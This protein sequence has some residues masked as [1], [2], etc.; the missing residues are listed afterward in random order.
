MKKKGKS[1]SKI[2][3]FITFNCYISWVMRINRTGK[4]IKGFYVLGHASVPVYLLD[5]PFPALFDA[6]FTGLARVYEKGILEVL[7][8]CPPS[9][10][11]LT[12]AHWDHIGSAAYFKAVWPQ[13]QIAGSKKA[14]D[15]VAQPKV[16]RRIRALNQNAIGALKSWGVPQVY[17]KMFESPAFDQVMN[18]GQTI[19]LG[20]GLSV[21]VIPTPGHTWDFLSYWVPEKK[22]LIA[23]EAAG[24][25]NVSEFLVDYDAYRTSLETLSELDVEVLCTGHHMVLTGADARKH[26]LD[27][28]DQAADYVARVERFLLDEDRDIDRVVQRIKI[29]EWDPKPLPKQPEKAYIINTKARVGTVLKRMLKRRGEKNDF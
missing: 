11:F 19:E 23:S 12:H 9:Y 1:K 25:D 29:Q 26:L 8:T 10:L 28:L 21:N 16:F 3:C 17:E 24:C 14:R 27:S 5:G 22:I 2:S 18:P 15:I 4:I 6:G 7:G 20:P 13:L